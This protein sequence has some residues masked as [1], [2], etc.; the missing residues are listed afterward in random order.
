MGG[1]IMSYKAIKGKFIVKGFSPDG[2]SIRFVADD[3][4]NQKWF[5]WGKGTN[6]T[7]ATNNKEIK[8]QLRM[9]AIDALETHYN[10]KYHQ[11][12]SFGIAGM[13]TLLQLLGIEVYKYSI[14]YTKIVEADDGKDGYII[15]SG[16]DMY[17][18]PVSF[19]FSGK[20]EMKDG[21]ELKSLSEQFIKKSLNYSLLDRGIVYPT[22]Y[23]GIDSKILEVFRKTTKKA[24][25]EKRGIW[26]IDKT[27]EFTFWETFTI[28]DDVVILPKLFRRL[29]TFIDEYSEYNQL[30]LYFKKSKDPVRLLNSNVDKDFSEI[31][32]IEGRN[33]RLKEFP[34]DLLFIPK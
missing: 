19:L 1:L 9:E 18:R 32:E 3:K 17:D 15:S 14:D 8:M 26:A 22:F 7:K 25:K 30:Q 12:R 20:S 11:P 16:L 4:Q 33:I 2:D 24:R 29:A 13:D 5:K 6:K 28:Q 27:P 34:E 10:Y 23:S 21:E 31:L